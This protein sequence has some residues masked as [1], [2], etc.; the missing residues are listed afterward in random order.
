MKNIKKVITAA[1]AGLIAAASI[2]TSAGAVGY[3]EDDG[4]HRSN[5]DHIENFYEDEVYIGVDLYFGYIY[6]HPDYGYYT[7]YNDLGIRYIGRDF[8]FTEYVATD[9]H[10]NDVYYREG[11]GNIYRIGDTWYRYNVYQGGYINL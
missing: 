8:K 9:R 7:Y 10:G 6:Y 4:S 11:V 5:V 2:A 1:I 3:I